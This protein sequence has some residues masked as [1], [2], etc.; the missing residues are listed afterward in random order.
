MEVLFNIANYTRCLCPVC[1]VQSG[2]SCIAGKEAIWRETRKAAGRVLEAYAVNPETY[3]LEA[4]L[5]QEHEVG[6]RS[7]FKKPAESEMK[8]LYCAVGRSECSDLDSDR[9]CLCGDCA[10][11]LA[12][13]LGHR[14]FCLMG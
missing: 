5:L 2:S 12:H 4:G 13:L 7:G 3:E 10:V 11:W 8:E 9:L 1:K 14:Y 6:K